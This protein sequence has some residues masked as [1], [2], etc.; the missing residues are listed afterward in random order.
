ML[1]GFGSRT[2]TAIGLIVVA[3]IAVF[4]LA[5][6]LQPALVTLVGGI[7]AALVA[8]GT[9]DG[10]IETPRQLPATPALSPPATQEVIEAIVE[11]VLIVAE[12]RVTHANAVAL[13]LLGKH[14]VGEDVRVAIR[15]PGAAERL[16][17]PPAASPQ[18]PTNLVGLGTLDQHWEM[19]VSRAEGGQRIV[20]LVDRTGNYAAE[21]M[22]VDFV[23]NASHELRTPLASI[24]GYI[25]TLGDD[26]AGEDAQVRGRFL[27]IMF[28]EARRMQRLVEDLISLSRIEAEKYR[29]PDRAVDIGG[30]IGE[31]RS[32]LLDAQDK[33]SADIVADI[34]LSVPP[35]AGDRAQLSQV[36]HN[37]IGNAM[38]YGRAGT[39]VTVK[40]WRDPAGMVRISVTDEG[41]GIAPEHIPRLTERFYR[42]D[43]GRSRAAGGTGL[44]LAIVK[45]IIERHRG[46][47]DVA[48][49]VGKG[50]TVT[51]LLPA[52]GQSGAVI[53][54]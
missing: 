39:P 24:L 45:H 13:G 17:G 1:Q 43:P 18:G 46:R 50:T 11:P 28:D 40:L 29:L 2:I 30:L 53:K 19:H 49:V 4:L 22:R 38:K 10:P 36:L 7:A 14:I 8:T 12:G 5:G 47:F 3:A 32:E 6:D 52:H 31:V 27:K 20:Q 42:V 44:G 54:R 34:D 51:I 37:L 23:A 25:E 41:E 33:R 21:R 16:A 26:K 15:H 9:G 48:S 35:V